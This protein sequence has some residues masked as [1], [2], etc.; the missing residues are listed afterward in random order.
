MMCG[1]IVRIAQWL[2]CL[3]TPPTAYWRF[4]VADPREDIMPKEALSILDQRTHASYDTVHQGDW[5]GAKAVYHINAVDA[6]TQWE[7][8]GCA[9]RISERHLLPV[10]EAMLHQFP[11][12][13]LGFHA[14][15]GSALERHSRLA[16]KG[17]LF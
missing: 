13:I 6:V 4:R 1:A 5:E 10:L 15:N 7:I 9:A 3:S 14:D 16:A 8:V 11:F 12:R 2:G 17:G